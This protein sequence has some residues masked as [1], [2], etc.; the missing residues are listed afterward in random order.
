MRRPLTSLVLLAGLAAAPALGDTPDGAAGPPPPADDRWVLPE[1][2]RQG[3]LLTPAYGHLLLHDAGAVLLAPLH[4]DAGD[5][6]RFGLATAGIVAAGALDRQ[7]EK[8]VVDHHGSGMDGVTKFF[9][10]FGAEYSFAV[11]GGFGIAGWLLDD[12]NA[13]TVAQD[14]IAATLIASGIIA[15]VLKVT[16][17]RSRPS[18][19]E[20]A[21]HFQPFHGGNSFP[22]GH[23]TQAFAVASV[24]SAHYD[25]WWISG[26][27]YGTA[28]MVGFARMY[29]HAH[30]FSDVVAGGL[31]GTVTGRTLVRVNDAARRDGRLT[32]APM[33]GRDARGVTL[34]YAF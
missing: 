32:W 7:V 31:I 30:F 11:I 12:T 25:S 15:P 27:A 19:E 28:G 18:A 4:W 13:R 1:D 3:A 29:H 9:E 23:A 26:I 8:F 2:L 24:I 10:P 16:S 5:W 6:G 14:S 34:S 33:V 22:S 20:G 21:Y 17:G